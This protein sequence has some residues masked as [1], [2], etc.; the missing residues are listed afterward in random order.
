MKKIAMYGAAI[1][2]A[3]VVV[4]SGG[5]FLLTK[6]RAENNLS[7][8]D[9][10]NPDLIKR[11]AYVALTADCAGCHSVSG[12]PLY[13]GGLAMQS[14]IGTIYSPNITPDKKFGIGTYTYAEFRNA[15]KLGIRQDGAP[16]YPA[17]PFPSYRIMPD[18]DI[19]AMYAYFMA[20]VKPL[21]KEVPESSIPWPLNMRWPMAWW[22]LMFS[23]DKQFV[24]A[25]G[26]NEQINHGA[27]LVEGPE[28]CG[29]CHTPRGLLFQEK[30]SSISDGSA[31][32]SGSSME[33]WYAKNLRNNSDGLKKWT[34][35]DIEEFLKTGRNK[36][37]AAYGAMQPVVEYSTQF[38]SDSDIKSIAAYL[39]S[40]SPS[41]NAD[42]NKL[43]VPATDKA[44]I[45]AD[46]PT[47][48]ALLS[49]RGAIIYIEQCSVCHKKDGQGVERVFP[50]L[51]GN[52]S[53]IT[54]NA[55]SVI[56]VTLFGGK[57]SKN[58]DDLMTFAM[59]GF[60]DKLNDEEMASVVNFIRQ[61]WSNKASSVTPKDIANMRK[62]VQEKSS[63]ITL[64]EEVT[65]EK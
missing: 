43:P 58:S 31:F 38:L 22:Q 18:R 11:G 42:E 53:V 4:A 5:A 60:A 24:P 33:G 65:N 47:K 2:V 61:G 49:N 51:N 29:A 26:E 41:A 59:P 16:L 34:Q 39:K 15:V 50:A 62:L 13:S 57:M 19:E 44:E 14:P 9:I 8:T 23:R 12:E 28:H 25:A 56:Q 10:N 27:Y 37:S 46:K 32:L 45:I 6:F 64:P 3:G 36:Y 40:L 48:D 7:F 52:T 17:M 55:D 63:N 54:N 35:T 21:K 1:I 20:A 30:S